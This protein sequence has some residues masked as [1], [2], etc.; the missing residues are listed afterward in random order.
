MDIIPLPASWSVR[1][2]IMASE[3]GRWAVWATASVGAHAIVLA[4][5]L[6]SVPSELASHAGPVVMPVQLV[7]VSPLSSASRHHPPPN[8]ASSQPPATAKPASIRR[9]RGHTALARMAL[10]PATLHARQQVAKAKSVH[11]HPP[12]AA[13]R[14]AVPPPADI[15]QASAHDLDLVRRHLERFKYYPEDARRRGIGGDVDIGFRLTHGGRVAQV[16]ID[17]SSGYALLD[18][19][20]KAIVV[21]AVPFPVDKG[22]YRVRLRFWP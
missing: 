11:V 12:A 15:D 22:R 5:M 18:R 9:R 20:A 19:A 8:E 14:A 6:V 7:P 21:R 3:R 17:A 2:P 16:K 10:R 13:S 1:G 4:A